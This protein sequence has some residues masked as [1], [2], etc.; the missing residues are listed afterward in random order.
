[1]YSYN[2]ELF[3]DIFGEGIF[4]EK[5]NEYKN[6]IGFLKK[7]ELLNTLVDSE[8]TVIKNI[9]CKKNYDKIINNYL[10]VKENVS[11]FMNSDIS[12]VRLMSLSEIEDDIK[13]YWLTKGYNYDELPTH[14]TKEIRKTA[15]TIHTTL[16]Q[17]K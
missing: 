12:K 17:Y 13:E 4:L 3:Y 11:K 6:T 14:I 8:D 15:Y 1:M 5:Y 16:N 7:C 9:K 2:V 10:E